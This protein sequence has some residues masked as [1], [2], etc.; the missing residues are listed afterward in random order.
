MDMDM[1]N[2]VT[3]TWTCSRKACRQASEYEYW[4]NSIFVM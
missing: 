1:L 2:K 3:W 4:G